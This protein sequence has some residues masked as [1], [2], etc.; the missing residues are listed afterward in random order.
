MALLKT[1]VFD[2]VLQDADAIAKVAVGAARVVSDEG[3]SLPRPFV[4][5]PVPGPNVMR[6]E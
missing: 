5:S 2:E 3:P 4:P 6:E 1:C